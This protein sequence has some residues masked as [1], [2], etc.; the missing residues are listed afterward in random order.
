MPFQFLIDNCLPGFSGLIVDAHY[1]CWLQ[2]SI[3]YRRRYSL[4]LGFKCNQYTFSKA[5]AVSSAFIKN[6]PYIYSASTQ[7]H[8]VSIGVNGYNIN[9]SFGGCTQR[10]VK[11][12]YF[13]AKSGSC[14]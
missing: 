6:I 13:P 11:I 1:T 10:A 4:Y 3:S 2:S 7:N 12:A 8:H 5:T 9:A 14:Q